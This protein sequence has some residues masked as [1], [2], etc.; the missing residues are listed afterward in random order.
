MLASLG[1]LSK[2]NMTKTLDRMFTLAMTGI[3]SYMIADVIHEVIGHGGTCLIISNKINLLTCAY[4]KSQPGNVFV[5]MGGPMANLFFG[6]L[7]FFLLKK[8]T[9][10]KLLLLQITAYNLF[11]FS[12]TI[13]QSAISKTVDWTFAANEITSGLSEKFLLLA[14]GLLFYSLFVRMLKAY[15][16]A[17]FKESQSSILKREDIF[18]S[19]LFAL[20]GAFIAGLFFKS[21][22]THSAFE[23]SLEMAASLPVLLLKFAD[24]LGAINHKSEGNRFFNFFVFVVF[25]VFCLTLGKGITP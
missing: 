7:S 14:A 22:R 21:D 15:L 3:L 4:F 2:S 25:L 1:R 17:N 12:G 13:L 19:F 9:F 8:T 23:C 20:V 10:P 11:W 24:K 6:G 18:F 16:A 5:D